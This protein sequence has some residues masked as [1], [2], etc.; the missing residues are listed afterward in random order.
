MATIEEARLWGIHTQDDSL[1]LNQ[2]VIAIGWQEFGD[3]S[4]V[5]QTRDAFKVRYEQVYPDAK[6]GS[7]ATGAGMLYRFCCEVKKGDYVVFPSKR[8]RQVNIGIIESEYVYDSTQPEY[9][10]TRKVKWIKHLPRTT[11]SQGALYEIG[12]ALS[13]FTVKNYADEFLA[14][15]SGKVGKS[16]VNEDVEDESVGATADEII[17][18]TRDFIIKELSRQLKGYELEEFVADLLQA[19]GYRTTVSPHGGDSGIDITAYK[20]ELPPRILV[21]VKSQDGDIKET[22]IQS[23]KGAMREGDYGLFVTLSN[24]TKNARK[25]LENTPIIRGINGTELVDLV[26]KYYKDMSERFRKLIPLRMVYIPVP[27]E[28]GE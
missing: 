15:L 2:N 24:Y 20:D 17:E 27:K 16:I 7:I 26:L 23:L 25:Y 8:D 11:F 19:M 4:K 21:Q 12:S 28:D 10:Q 22:T 9:V 1:F 3:L 6:K 18:S 5:E 13:F 14:A